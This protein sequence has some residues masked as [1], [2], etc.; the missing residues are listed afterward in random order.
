MIFLEMTTSLDGYVAAPGVSLEHPLGEDGLRLHD[1]LLGDS[2]AQE[3]EI[4]SRTFAN[5]GAFL[6]GRRMFDVGEEPWGDDGAFGRPCFVVTHRP[7]PTLVKGPTTFTFVTDGIES[8]LGQAREAAGDA[9]ICVVGGA[10]LARQY[11]RAGVV[12]EL[13]LH[14]VPV[15]LGGGT[16]LWD[17]LTR[18]ELRTTQ[19]VETPQA[20]HLTFRLR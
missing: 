5:T 16:L 10:E 20:T 11:L 6:L 7:R 19:V 2:T 9:D 4:A 17:G 14:L 18:T 13:R 3:K 15:I 12:D 1:W 8:A